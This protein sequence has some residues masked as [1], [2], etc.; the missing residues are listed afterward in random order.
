MRNDIMGNKI[1]WLVVQIVICISL[2][3]LTK[4]ISVRLTIVHLLIAY[5]LSFVIAKML[6][7]WVDKR[8]ARGSE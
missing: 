4:G 1:L 8:N 2:L 5:I 3:W 7:Y 6:A